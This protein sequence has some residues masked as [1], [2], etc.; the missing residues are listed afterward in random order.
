LLAGVELRG[1]LRGAKGGTADKMFSCDAY[2]THACL[3]ELGEVVAARRVA[4]ICDGKLQWFGD[5]FQ[6]LTDCVL[7][8]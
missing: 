1:S 2:L 4:L 3:P 5:L 6:N 8:R 7:R